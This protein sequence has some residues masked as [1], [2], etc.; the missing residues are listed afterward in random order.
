M[1]VP[2]CGICCHNMG[3]LAINFE[4]F[5]TRLDRFIGK[6][7]ICDLLVQWQY[8]SDYHLWGIVTGGIFF[9]PEFPETAD[10][11][12]GES[13]RVSFSLVIQLEP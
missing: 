8:P 6:S 4:G 2:I 12:W 13:S 7:S 3:V 5:K 11:P 10:E 9:S 1:D